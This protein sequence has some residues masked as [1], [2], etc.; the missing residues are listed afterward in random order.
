MGSCHTLRHCQ[1][2]RACRCGGKKSRALR[3]GPVFQ[4]FVQMA[5]WDTLGSGM[6]QHFAPEL[7]AG[8]SK[9]TTFYKGHTGLQ[10]WLGGGSVN[11]SIAGPARDCQQFSRASPVNQ[12]LAGS[13]PP[14]PRFL[15]Y[16]HLKQSCTSLFDNIGFYEQLK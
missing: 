16:C 1:R 7:F 9:T 8:T 10:I 2:A 12:S 13:T 14:P 11:Q 4:L 6:D 15:T 3:Q 5:L